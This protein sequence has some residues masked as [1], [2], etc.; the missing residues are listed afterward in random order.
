MPPQHLLIYYAWPT[1][2]PVEEFARYQHVVL[3]DG[4]QDP[5]H[6]S[7]PEPIIKACPQTA[8]YGYVDVGVSTQN[9]S[10]Q[11]IANRCRLWKQT[12]VRGVLLDDFGYDFGVTRARQSAAVRSAHE[13]GLRVIANAWNPADVFA[14]VSVLGENDL[15]LLESFQLQT[16]ERAARMRAFRCRNV[17]SIV[18]GDFSQQT[19]DEAYT[20]AVHEGHLACGWGEPSYSS[21]NGL[22][23]F[24]ERKVCLDL[25]RSLPT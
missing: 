1:C 8:F 18:T 5:A 11:E 12:G 14:P 21:Q 22:A 3:G 9:L 24:R 2:L 20:W 25:A 15:Y 13:A 6:P 4:L 7:R 19:Y 17:L 23:P 10:P 16:R